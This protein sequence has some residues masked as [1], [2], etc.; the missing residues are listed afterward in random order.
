MDVRDAQPDSD[1]VVEV[2]LA[3]WGL[4]APPV[5]T[6]TTQRRHQPPLGSPS[7]CSSPS[8]MRRAPQRWGYGRTVLFSFDHVLG[9]LATQAEVYEAAARGVVEGTLEGYGGT[10]FCYGQTGSGKTHTMEGRLDGSRE[11]A[12]ILPRA[13]EHLFEVGAGLR[14]FSVTVSSVE[15]GSAERIQDL[16]APGGANLA[17]REC[18]GRGACVQH[19]RE[20]D[21][22]SAEELLE[23]ARVAVSNRTTA[24]TMKNEQSS[25]S[26]S[27]FTIVVSSVSSA[28]VQRSGTLHL[29]DLAGSERQKQTQAEGQRLD[30]VRAINRSLSALGNVVAA[31]AA[32]RPDLGHVPYRDSKLTR[33]LRE[34]LGGNART[35]IVLTVSPAMADRQ[36]TLSSLRFGSR[37]R[38]VRNRPVVAGQPAR[39]LC[40][41]DYKLMLQQHQCEIRRLQGL[42][43][44]RGASTATTQCSSR[45]ADSSAESLA[46]EPPDAS[47]TGGSARF[48]PV[49]VVVTMEEQERALEDAVR[50]WGSTTAAAAR[51]FV[52]RYTHLRRHADHCNVLSSRHARDR[53]GRA[54]NRWSVEVVLCSEPRLLCR[55]LHE[56][57]EEICY[58]EEQFLQAM[59]VPGDEYWPEVFGE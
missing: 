32:G 26:H 5:A 54:A 21:V 23:T 52:D 36:E 35:A 38:L 58:T 31:L 50:V 48:D 40:E 24:A 4:D 13:A 55:L 14:G 11:G 41:E 20:V 28:G 49:P 39:S 17:I 29:V 37:A 3:D 2:A 46:L 47:S 51:A 6:P 45:T 25:R 22:R 10:V 42:L 1:P 15:I 53:S 56:G 7:P 16:L 34:A 18:S 30:E 33:M 57:T 59:Q 19:C 8:A 9:E 12:G 27:I 44:G 43:H